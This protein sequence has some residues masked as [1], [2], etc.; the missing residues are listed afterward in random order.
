MEITLRPEMQRYAEQQIATGKYPSINEMLN[1]L[2][3]KEQEQDRPEM[4]A[5]TEWTV[6]EI[7][8]MM[9][10]SDARFERGEYLT[11]P[12]EKLKDFFDDII[13][14]GEQRFEAREAG[15]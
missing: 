5:D 12:R 8:Q 3:Q 6:A 4:Y 11:V 14:R 13:A 7:D 10:E 1:L 2:I 15:K 9:A